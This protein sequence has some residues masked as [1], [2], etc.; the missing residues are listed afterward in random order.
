VEVV[1]IGTTTCGKPFGF[2]P[3]DNCGETYYTIQFQGVNDQGFG[4]YADGFVAANSSAAFGVRAPGCAVGDDLSRDLGDPQEAMLSAALGF[5]ATGACPTPP[6]RVTAQS[7][8]AVR[9]GEEAFALTPPRESVM[10][11]NRDMTPAR[12]TRP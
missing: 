5:R 12:E 2:F 10:T 11:L 1:L 6:A 4:D 3:T 9:D 8:S 7:V